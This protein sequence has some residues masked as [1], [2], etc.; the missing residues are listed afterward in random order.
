M[1][2]KSTLG[3]GRYRQGTCSNVPKLSVMHSKVAWA[4]RSRASTTCAKKY[5]LAQLRKLLAL[6]TEHD[7]DGKDPVPL[8]LEVTGAVHVCSTIGTAE[9]FKCG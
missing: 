4:F 6:R 3:V 2:T 9:R 8:G 1:E 7:C 5:R